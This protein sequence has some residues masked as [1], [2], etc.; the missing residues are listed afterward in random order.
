MRRRDL[1]VHRHEIVFAV[2]L[3]AVAG[4]VHE[5]D[6]IWSR[7]LSLVEEVPERRAQ[8]FAIEVARA[9]DIEAGCLQGLGDEARVIGWG[10]KWT[11]LVGS[12]AD[13]ERNA[14]FRFRPQ[15]RG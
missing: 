5:R 13:H 1:R 4:E 3:R 9:G 7:C 12:V 11:R 2:E 15:G 6:G 10:G 8:R 14:F